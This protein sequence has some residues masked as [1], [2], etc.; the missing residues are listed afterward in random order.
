MR[1][2]VHILRKPRITETG[3]MMAEH[4]NIVIFEVVRN[5]NKIEI[6]KAIQSAFN[7]EVRNVR[8]M[9]VRGKIKRRGRN[10]G[11][12]PTW[13]KAIVTLSEGSEIDF[14]GGISV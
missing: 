2:A 9:I 5:A 6:K 1:E 8:T 10:I 4:G 11:K 7:V 12:R 3:S 13:K 14:F